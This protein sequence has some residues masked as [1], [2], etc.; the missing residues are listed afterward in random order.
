MMFAWDE[1][2]ERERVLLRDERAKAEREEENFTSLEG[3]KALKEKI[4]AHWR[5]KGFKPP[6]IELVEVGFHASIR[7]CRYDLRSNM[8]GGMPL[9][10]LDAE[11][12]Q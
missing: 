2:E 11:V 6:K 3:A 8:Q 9:E 5:A 7:A 4:E 10:R 12:A 1:F